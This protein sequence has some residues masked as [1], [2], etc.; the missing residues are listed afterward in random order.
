M[1]IIDKL[2]Y[3]G[4]ILIA[5]HLAFVFYGNSQ[6][7]NVNT[8]DNAMDFVTCEI[9]NIQLVKEIK[10]FHAINKGYNRNQDRAFFL[11]V[12]KGSDSTIYNL[13]YRFDYYEL[14][15]NDVVHQIG[16]VDN[17]IVF[18]SFSGV[19]EVKVPD[20]VFLKI[21]KKKFKEAYQHFLENDMFPI[22]TLY[23]NVP[24]W[25]LIFKNG[26]LVKREMFNG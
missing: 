20:S 7:A 4:Y 15:V 11:K 12:S 2:G 1:E 13:E 17:L 18:F 26:E 21:A 22:N 19:N 8:D 14:G 24:Y 16:M 9:L 23:H 6:K 10:K 25:R 5:L 3:K